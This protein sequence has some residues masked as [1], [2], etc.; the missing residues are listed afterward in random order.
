MLPNTA[1]CFATQ[2]LTT[3]MRKPPRRESALERFERGK[4]GRRP[5][6]I[7]VA[8]ERHR[9]GLRSRVSPSAYDQIRAE[10]TRSNGLM[11]NVLK[12]SIRATNL[13]RTKGPFFGLKLK[14]VGSVLDGP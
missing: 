12:P 2:L 13:G 14:A 4:S 3:S 9:L 11:P 6:T 10:V 8:A 1:R 7:A 5:M